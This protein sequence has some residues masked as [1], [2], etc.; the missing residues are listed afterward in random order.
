M[1]RKIR[2]LESEVKKERFSIDESTENLD[3]LKPR[4]MAMIDKLDHDLKQINTNAD[5]LRKNF[6]ELTESKYNLIMT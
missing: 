6:N 4:E 5:A 2:F 3:A 1:E